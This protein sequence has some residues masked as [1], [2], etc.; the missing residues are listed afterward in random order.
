MTLS[1]ILVAAVV[2]LALSNGANDN[3][4]GVAA[5]FG[6]RTVGYWTA[7]AWATVTTAAGSLAAI[8]LAAALLPRFSGKGLVPDAL[9]TTEPY[10][11]AIVAGAALTIVIAS[12]LGLPISTTLSLIHISEPTRPY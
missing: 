12:V 11:V 3:F 9:A 6:S 8:A 5:L 10:L 4:K 1:L 7:L 2:L